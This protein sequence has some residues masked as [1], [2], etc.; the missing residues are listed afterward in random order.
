MHI[1]KRT[2]FYLGLIMITIGVI[3]LATLLYL[4]PHD[5]F[6][7][8]NLEI[9]YDD[10]RGPIFENIQAGDKFEL[11]FDATKPVNVLL[12]KEE[13]AS[14]YFN[15]PVPTVQPIIFA[16]ESKGGDIDHTFD[17]DGNW[18]LYF[19]NPYP[20][21]RSTP[22]VSYSGQLIKKDDNITFYYLNIALS[23][24]LIIVA[25]VLLF[26]SKEKKP[27]KISKNK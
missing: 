19:E 3:F 12:L 6:N 26:S 18:A 2:M 22:K 16:S 1:K 21:P 9:R 5:K 4:G 15:T 7:E 10:P 13:E 23:I 20:P 27:L 25:L 11:T 24:I 14:S 8:E 17:A